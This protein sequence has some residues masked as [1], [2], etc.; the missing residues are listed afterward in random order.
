MSTA[1]KYI[2]DKRHNQRIEFKMQID[3]VTETATKYLRDKIIVGEFSDGEKLNEVTLS[4]DLNISRPPIREALRT[5]ENEKLVLRIPRKGTFV[6]PLSREDCDQLFEMRRLIEHK[7]IEMIFIQERVDKA[8][9]GIKRALKLAKDYQHPQNPTNE[10]LLMFFRIFREFHSEIIKASGNN[11]LVH[12]N[13][14]IKAALARY[15]MLYLKDQGSWTI[16][17][18]D[19]YE[20][21]KYIQEGDPENAIKSLNVHVDNVTNLVKPHL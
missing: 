17:I 19:H 3:G 1:L 15:Q 12:L 16:S 2:V 18:N 13:Q 21:I 9:I 8:L 4:E 6:T 14:T 7:A 10:D 5:L 11:W 20:I